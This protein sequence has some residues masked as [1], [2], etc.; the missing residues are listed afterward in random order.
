M[1]SSNTVTLDHV[2]TSVISEVKPHTMVADE[3]LS[4]SIKA[5]IDSINEGRPGHIVECGVW[6]GGSSFAML[7]AQRYYFGK[8]VKPVWMFDSFQGLPAAEPRDGPAAIAY[9]ADPD[10]PYYFDN[11]TAS[12][13]EVCEQAARFGF[14]S[15]EA[16]IV[17]GWFQDSVPRVIAEIARLGISLL[18]IDCDWYDPVRYTLEQ[19][20]PLVVENG[21][22]ILDDYF[23]WDGCVRATHDY[24]SSNDLPYRIRS[25]PSLQGAWL[26]KQ[27]YGVSH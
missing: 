3:A 2:I 26:I 22:I 20:E 4:F 9:Q 15:R 1:T 8:V 17:P 18:R 13:D 24:L 12:L 10:G 27:P 23:T 16:N 14:T 19:L 21:L 6:K 7:L 11:C 5:A 25:L